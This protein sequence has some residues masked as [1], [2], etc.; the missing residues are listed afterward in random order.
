MHK[1]CGEICRS[2]FESIEKATLRLQA[3]ECIP[4]TSART[5][6]LKR[7]L[8]MCFYFNDISYSRKH[9]HHLMDL[10]LFL[11]RLQD[12]AF[13]LTPQADYRELTALV[14]LLDIAVDDARSVGIDL[15]DEEKAYHFDTDV[16]ALAAAVKDLMKGIGN[17]GAAFI[18]KIEAKEALELV[19]QRIAD[20]LR[21]KPKPKDTVFD[22]P[23]RRERD[24]DGE[25]AG[26][27]SFLSKMKKTT[28][29]SDG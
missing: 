20:T 24:M 14:S 27:Q 7:R 5:H 19:A 3:V 16:D 18:S 4:S 6:D 9:S 21:S 2:L 28:P 22:G 1:Q 26:L 12:S 25:R 10:R 8:A 23:R 17:P 11:A 29:N 15:R 13:D